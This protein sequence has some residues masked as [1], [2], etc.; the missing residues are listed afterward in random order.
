M[1]GISEP[2]WIICFRIP[3]RSIINVRHPVAVWKSSS[4]SEVTSSLPRDTTLSEILSILAISEAI[5]LSESMQTLTNRVSEKLS[6]SANRDSFLLAMREDGSSADQ[7]LTITRLPSREPMFL[8]ASG[9]R[10]MEGASEPISREWLPEGMAEERKNV[11]IKK[12]KAK[13]L[14]FTITCFSYT[15]AVCASLLTLFMETT[16]IN[17]KQGE[18]GC[19]TCK[20]IVIPP[21]GLSRMEG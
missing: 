20:S 13:L 21:L 1:S 5:D 7:K 8:P 9:E 3:N 6:D 2:E 10:E 11:A 17:S 14:D 4:T 18:A 12:D 19:Q 16:K 15:I